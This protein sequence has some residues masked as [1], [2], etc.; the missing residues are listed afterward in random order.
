MKTKI[1]IV[2]FLGAF[3]SIIFRFQIGDFLLSKYGKTCTGIV[4][5]NVRSVKYVKP[6]YLYQFTID[7][8]SYEGNS[9]TNDTSHIGKSI[10]IVFLPLIPSINR[11]AVFLKKEC[12]SIIKAYHGAFIIEPV[13]SS[14]LVEKE[15][16]Q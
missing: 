8:S 3:L 2:V 4:T 11:P 15:K 13:F 16:H 12:N 14:F 6:T 10:C 9:M 5:S 1:I 7:K